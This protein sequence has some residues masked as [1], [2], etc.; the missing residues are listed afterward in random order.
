VR[1]QDRD[2]GILSHD[3]AHAPRALCPV[4]GKGVDGGKAHR[5]EEL[6]LLLPAEV[7]VQEERGARIIG[8]D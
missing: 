4:V 5:R 6:P 1:R 2:V 7:A 8:G 3:L